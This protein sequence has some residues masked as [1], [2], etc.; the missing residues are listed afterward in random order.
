VTMNTN[1]SRDVPAGYARV[2]PW[3]ISDDTDAEIHFLTEAFGAREHT[4]SRVL[5]QDGSIGHVEVDL[6][7]F[8]IMMFDQPSWTP[9]PSHLRVYADDAAETMARAVKAGAREVT[10]LTTLAFGE[11]V[12]RLRD[13]QGHLWWIHERF[14]DVSPDEL[15]ARSADPAALRAMRTSSSR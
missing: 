7:G 14:E 9:T 15:A 11:R 8:V 5:N 10:R 1:R 6:H 12:G 3:D 13:T 4:G 2:N